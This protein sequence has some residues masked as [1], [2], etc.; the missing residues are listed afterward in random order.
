MLLSFSPCN[1]QGISEFSN[2]LFFYFIFITTILMGDWL[3]RRGGYVCYYDY[4]K[5]RPPPKTYHAGSY[6]T[7]MAG[8]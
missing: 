4:K 8:Q 1:R 7:S 3:R 5:L 2:V 6:A